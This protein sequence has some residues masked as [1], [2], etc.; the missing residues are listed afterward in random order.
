MKKF[1]LLSAAAFAALLAGSSA[2]QAGHGCGCC[3]VV[4]APAAA[5]PAAAAQ[6][7]PAGTAVAQ[8][9]QG[10]RSYSYQPA[11][12]VSTGG[13]YYSGGRGRSN[14]PVWMNGANKSLGRVN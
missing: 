10:Y 5:S 9:N 6:A 14:S 8:A 7:A 4:Y 2:A 3:G 13:Y 1:V 11:A 12:A